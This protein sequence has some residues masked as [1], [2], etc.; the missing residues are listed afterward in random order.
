MKQENHEDY[1]RK[2]AI[3]SRVKCKLCFCK[4]LLVFVFLNQAGSMQ[5]VDK[6][7]SQ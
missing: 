7:N 2:Y 1:N 5:G 6:F 4:M 3:V